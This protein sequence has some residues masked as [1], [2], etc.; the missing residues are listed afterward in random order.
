MSTPAGDFAG[1]RRQATVAVLLVGRN[2]AKTVRAP[3]LLSVS[4]LQP[5][6]WLV[7]FS[8]TFKGLG[9][10]AQF[11][12]LG[13]HSYLSFFAPGM[14]VLS[15]LFTALQSGM[16]T[17]T[18]IGSG[19]MDK[20]VSSPVR[21]VTVLAARAWADAVTM[22]AQVVVVLG[23]SLAMGARL[24][25]GPGGALLMVV[26]ATA[27]GVIWAS[28]SNFIALRTRNAELTIAVGFLIT[29]PVLFLSSAFF[30]LQLQPG[31][32][33]AVSDAIPAAYVI[34][35]GQVLMNLGNSTGQ[36]LRTVAALMVTGVVLVPAAVSAF[37]A[38]AQ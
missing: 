30:P 9:R 28:L 36:D 27:F 34:K 18:D 22:I 35:A 2:I 16:A 38:R 7:L 33:Q 10:S 26:L 12:S 13:Y 23:L 6:L 19:M 14:M 31:W 17:V 20:F 8:Q 24:R 21:R 1:L 29:L 3:M 37:R 25:A 4:L 15:V 32:L 5:V 11:T